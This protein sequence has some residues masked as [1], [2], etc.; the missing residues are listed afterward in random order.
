MLLNYHE[1]TMNEPRNSPAKRKQMLVICSVMASVFF[2][3]C[4]T[5]GLFISMDIK[6]SIF[7][8]GH[9][10]YRSAQRDYAAASSLAKQ[11]RDDLGFKSEYSGDDIIYHVYLDDPSRMGGRRQRWMTGILVDNSGEEYMQQ[12]LSFNEEIKK[13]PISHE[14]MLQEPVREV[15]PRL[16][17]EQE[18]LPSVDAL[19]LN[20]P[21]T[22]GFVSSLVHSYRVS[23]KIYDV[24]CL[25]L[26]LLAA[27]V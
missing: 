13:N 24:L 23:S 15:W 27:H 6:E 18:D 3:S 26:F 16:L 1:M 7:P 5:S 2:Y 10:V 25:V 11:I 17:Y 21:F 22:N 19:V 9:F 14:D 4:W 12:L 20:F 8:G